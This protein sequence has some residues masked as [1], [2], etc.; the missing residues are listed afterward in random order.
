MLS[1]RVTI[2]RFTYFACFFHVKFCGTNSNHC[3]LQAYL[4]SRLGGSV[5]WKPSG[6]MS[7]MHVQDFKGKEQFAGRSVTALIL[8][9]FC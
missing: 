8:V 3:S 7:F 4:K 9:F 2:L 5:L 6:L 1:E